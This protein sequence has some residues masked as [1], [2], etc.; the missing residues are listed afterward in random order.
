MRSE[1]MAVLGTWKIDALP[2][3]ISPVSLPQEGPPPHPDPSS[4]QKYAIASS[5]GQLHRHII[6]LPRITTT[7]TTCPCSLLLLLLL[8]LLRF[9]ILQP[10][11]TKRILCRGHVWPVKFSD[12]SIA[13]PGRFFFIG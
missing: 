6:T 12:R 4:F 1:M 13:D 5:T 9:L 3:L 10:F 11:W 7:T 8:L 2:S